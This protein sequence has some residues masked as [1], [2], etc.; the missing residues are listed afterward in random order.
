MMT[1]TDGMRMRMMQMN[2]MGLSM[3]PQMESIYEPNIKENNERKSN[4][5]DGFV[6]IFRK[7]GEGFSDEPI[8]IHCLKSEKVSDLIQKYRNK[9]GDSDCF[10]KFIF[11]GKQLNGYLT[12]SEAGLSENANIFVVNTKGIKGAGYPMMFSDVSKNKTKEIFF[13]IVHL[14]IEKQVKELIFLVFVIVK[15][16]KLLIKK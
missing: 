3:N 10:K 8:M 4:D 15:N 11:N 16:V 1:P 12:V 14:H 2:Q 6:V 9:S 7:S 5:S 13:Q